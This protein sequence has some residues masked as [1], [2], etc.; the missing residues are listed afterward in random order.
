MKRFSFRLERLLQLRVMEEQDRARALAEARDAADDARRESEVSAERLADTAEQL[1]A[2]PPD[3][4]T[5][6]TLRN[7]ML[8]LEAAQERAESSA[9][10]HQEAQGRLDGEQTVFDR[11]RQER[12]TIER[13]REQGQAAWE[14]E[15]VQ[16]EQKQLDE[17]A[18]R[19][20]HGFDR[21]P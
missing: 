1:A 4:R 9:A 5:A 12:R 19:M 6:G 18:Q 2:T 11:A 15:V 14:D 20:P 21:Q 13:L 16:D 8:T 10:A 17:V 3:M 7:M